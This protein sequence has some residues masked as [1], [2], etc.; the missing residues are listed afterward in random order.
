MTTG[1]ALQSD[2]RKGIR[3]LDSLLRGCREAF[4]RQGSEP[5]GS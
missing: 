5:L 2:V 4:W 1:K 3:L